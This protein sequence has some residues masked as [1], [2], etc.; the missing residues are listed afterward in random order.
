[1]TQARHVAYMQSALDS[2]EARHTIAENTLKEAIAPGT[3]TAEYRDRQFWGSASTRREPTP[4]P[5]YL[6]KQRAV[7]TMLGCKTRPLKG[8]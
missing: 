1:M 8:V 2:T 6:R 4:R 7:S 5:R 3:A